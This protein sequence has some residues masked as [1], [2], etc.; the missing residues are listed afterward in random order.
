MCWITQ[1]NDPIT[2]PLSLEQQQGKPEMHLSEQSV[3]ECNL[4]LLL[5]FNLTEKYP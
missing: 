4:S 1:L 5:K 2:A 3:K